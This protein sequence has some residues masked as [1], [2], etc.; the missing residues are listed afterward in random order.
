MLCGI[1]NADV[2]A[3]AADRDALRRLT[4]RLG[5]LAEADLSVL[6]PGELA[7]HVTEMVRVHEQLAR[8]TGAAVRVAEQSQTHR[9]NSHKSM[10]ALIRSRTHLHTNH[11]ARYKTA[12]DSLDLFPSFAKAFADEQVTLGHLE[13]M[14]RLLARADSEQVMGAEPALC[15]LAV[16][17]TTEEFRDKAK[18]WEAAADPT[19]HLDDY[20]KAQADEHLWYGKDLFGNLHLSGTLSPLNGEAFLQ[21]LERRSDALWR[22]DQEAAKHDPGRS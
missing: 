12:A 22:E 18:E 21:A 7:D 10:T 4:L 6:S 20:N 15:A 11:A 13:V 8:L 19:E 2:E 14:T 3:L 1:N 9:A 16:L 5:L 17:C